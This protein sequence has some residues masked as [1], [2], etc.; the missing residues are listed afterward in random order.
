MKKNPKGEQIDLFYS[1][2]SKGKKNKKESKPK[3]SEKKTSNTFADKASRSKKTNKNA[4]KK[5]TKTKTI[6]LSN[7]IIIGMTPKKEEKA[8][9]QKSKKKN[10]GTKPKAVQ[11]KKKTNNKRKATSRPR[12]KNKKNVNREARIKVIKIVS[13]IFIGTA[14]LLLFLLSPV[15]NVKDIVVNGNNKLNSRGDYCSIWSSER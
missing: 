11:N 15:F 2:P 13:L 7:E 1:T 5:N 12:K 6:N 3:P 9:K 4:K 8:P 14:C 10:V